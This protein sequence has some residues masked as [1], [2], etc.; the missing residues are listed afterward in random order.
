MK[1]G[2]ERKFIIVGAL[3]NLITAFLTMFSYNSWFNQEGA[4]QIENVDTNTMIAGSQMINNISQIIFLYGLFILIGAIINFLIATKIR[5]ND[6]QNKLM[7][8][9]IIWAVTQLL[10]MD[11]IGFVL[12]MLAIVLYFSKNKAIRL[13]N[14]NLDESYGKKNFA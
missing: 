9:F 5:D 13:T 12:Y 4:K 7:I 8:W 2:L 11:V 1:R 14:K 6:I 10:A 3:W